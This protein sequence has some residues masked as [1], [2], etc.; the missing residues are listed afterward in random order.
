MNG[1]CDVKWVPEDLDRCDHGRHSID[2]C[3]SCPGGRSEG[4]MYLSVWVG[5]QRRNV[6]VRIGTT[7]GGEPIYVTPARFRNGETEVPTDE[8]G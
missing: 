2:D 8:Q 3:F 5:D 1:D 7:L 6:K 4:N